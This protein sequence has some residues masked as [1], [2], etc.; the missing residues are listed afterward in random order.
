MT[1]FLKCL[2]LLFLG[3][4]APRLSAQITDGSHWRSGNNPQSNCTIDVGYVNGSLSVTV[5]S[6]DGWAQSPGATAAPGSTVDEPA[7]ESFAPTSTPNGTY[8]GANGRVFRF[9]NG[10]WWPMGRIGAGSLP[11][12]GGNTQ[13]LQKGHA[14]PNAGFLVGPGLRVVW[15]DE[16]DIAPFTGKLCAPGDEIDSLPT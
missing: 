7:A 8:M 6:V 1:R 16:G 2:A 15:L 11:G 9:A 10:R 12:W 5:Q 3:L 4:F 13:T 14:A